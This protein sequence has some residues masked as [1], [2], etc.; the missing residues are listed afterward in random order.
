MIVINL[1]ILS[2]KHISIQTINHKILNAQI[3]RDNLKDNI[4]TMRIIL[5]KTIIRVKIFMEI[6][7]R[8]KNK[9]KILKFHKEIKKMFNKIKMK[10][11]CNFME[12]SQGSVEDYKE[13]LNLIKNQQLHQFIS[14]KSK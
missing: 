8:I 13:I 7:K 5:G 10:T 9:E 12:R 3:V 6:L 14:K 2:R 1:S 11:I 4:I